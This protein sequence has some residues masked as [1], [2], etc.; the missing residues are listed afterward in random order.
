M[1]QQGPQKKMVVEY[2]F[3]DE[4]KRAIVM[5]GSIEG[6]NVQIPWYEHQFTFR[7]GMNHVKEMEKTAE[8]L[9]GKTITVEFAG[10]KD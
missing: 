8:L 2:A 1:S 4:A 9:R 5:N 10:G 6:Q 3:Y 7:E